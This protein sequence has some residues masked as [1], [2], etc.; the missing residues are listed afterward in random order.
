M[1]LRVRFVRSI[2]VDRWFIW[3]TRA[4]CERDRLSL[5]SGYKLSWWWDNKEVMDTEIG[6][7]EDFHRYSSLGALDRHTRF[8]AWHG[9]EVYTCRIIGIQDTRIKNQQ[10]PKRPVIGNSTCVVLRYVKSLFIYYCLNLSYYTSSD[11]SYN[12]FLFGR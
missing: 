10:E 3:I 6:E 12:P 4:W 9:F 7:D 1:A 11:T 2:A 5:F 8:E